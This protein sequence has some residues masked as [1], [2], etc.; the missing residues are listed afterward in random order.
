MCRSQFMWCMAVALGISLL[1]G[2]GLS[3][4]GSIPGLPGILGSS[5]KSDPAVGTPD[6]GNRQT[7]DDDASESDDENEVEDADEAGDSDEI[8]DS[9]EVDDADEVG[10]V[11]EVDDADEANDDEEDDG[12]SL[13]ALNAEGSNAS[14][15]A[16]VVYEEETDGRSFEVQIVG[17]QPGGSVDVILSGQVLAS[18]TLDTNGS[19][20]VAF[21]STPE[22]PSEGPLAADFPALKAGDVLSVGGLSL[23]L[24]V[25][26]DD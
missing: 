8:D 1:A 22:D 11:D 18:L 9:N 17:G 4:S 21:S 23:T 20:E 24:T 12:Q 14:L 16:E 13:L 19:G 2:C 25:A 3:G 26:E 10:N 6:G 7:D 5:S 15:Q